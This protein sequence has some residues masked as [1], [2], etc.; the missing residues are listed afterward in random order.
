MNAKTAVRSL[1]LAAC[2]AGFL[3][4]PGQCVER[5]KMSPLEVFA[6]ILNLKNYGFVCPGGPLELAELTVTY[7][8][9]EPE[10]VEWSE[11]MCNCRDDFT[12]DYS[13][14]EGR[15]R[16][17]IVADLKDPRIRDYKFVFKDL[18]LRSGD[19]KK[20]FTEAVSVHSEAT[21]KDNT[22]MRFIQS[23]GRLT[24]RRD[25]ERLRLVKQEGRNSLIAPWRRDRDFNPGALRDVTSVT[26][27]N[28]DG[29][30]SGSAVCN[31]S[32]CT[33]AEAFASGGG[34]CPSACPAGD[35]WPS[36]AG[37]ACDAAKAACV[38]L[39]CGPYPDCPPFTCPLG[40][41]KLVCSGPCFLNPICI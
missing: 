18:S 40:C 16:D 41:V 4:T 39:G 29:T 36:G 15:D 12:L 8:W 19:P 17:A 13:D 20:E 28:A 30:T 6:A 3:A 35:C 7:E 11:S 22:R 31:N 32:G 26:V 23:N 21:W 9:Y 33:Q 38:A 34:G 24:F 2:L 5:R 14:P 37:A 25:K 10:V 27:Y 1:A